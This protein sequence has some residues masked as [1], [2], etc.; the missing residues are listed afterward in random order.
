MMA[1]AGDGAGRG[2]MRGLVVQA[3]A[4]RSQLAPRA[5]QPATAVDLAPT[6][7]C[8]CRTAALRSRPRSTAASR[9]RPPQRR[10]AQS[11][12]PLSRP[13]HRAAAC[14]CRL[15]SWRHGGGSR[16][17]SSS[18]RRG[19]RAHHAEE[20]EPSAARRTVAERHE[21]DDEARGHRTSDRDC[22]GRADGL[23]EGEGEEARGACGDQPQAGNA[24]GIPP[25]SSFSQPHM[26]RGFCIHGW[27]GGRRK[28]ALFGGVAGG[29][30]EQPDTRAAAA[31]ASG[32]ARICSV[33]HASTE[34]TGGWRLQAQGGEMRDEQA[35]SA[36]A[37]TALCARARRGEAAAGR[38]RP[39]TASPEA[40]AARD[41][42][43]PQRAP[44]SALRG[45]EC[46]ELPRTGHTRR[47]AQP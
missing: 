45:A 36:H 1:P 37:R 30:G 9:S 21:E 27:G 43:S 16:A 20:R 14:T 5:Q 40:L 2:E 22:E 35:M 7:P 18:S 39:A 25:H 34:L 29:G 10:A 33:Q 47:G 32:P 11:R 44:P 13:H 41:T 12:R 19:S 24:A 3:H 42:A 4:Q 23:D 46:S 28:W 6:H 8:W 17:V 38:C 31:S 26:R 15:R